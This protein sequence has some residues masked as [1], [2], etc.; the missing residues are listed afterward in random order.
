MLKVLVGAVRSNV[1]TGGVA[2]SDLNPAPSEA[3]LYVEQ[4]LM[5]SQKGQARRNIGTADSSIITL[6]GEAIARYVYQLKD[7]DDIVFYPQTIER[8]VIDDDGRTLHNK[9]GD[10]DD[11]ETRNKSSIVAAINEAAQTGSG[12]SVIL[13]YVVVNSIAEL[14]IPGEPTIGYLVGENLYVYVG[15]GGDT[16]SGAYQNC[17]AFRGPQGPQG[18]QGVQGVQ[19]VPGQDGEAAG[20]GTPTATVDANVGTPSVSVTASGPDTAK[21]FTFTFTNLKG[22]PGA[23]GADGAQGPPGVTSAVVT[24][25][26]TSG[27]PAAQVSVSEGVLTIAF[28]GLKGLQGNSG[29]SGAAGELQ[30][31]NNLVDGGTTDAL[32]AEMGK[33]LKGLIDGKFVFLTESE[34]AALT[35]KDPEKIYCTY[36]DEEEEVEE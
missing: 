17:G 34:Y 26:N 11:L 10:L 1:V 12:G 14:P 33:D 8:A 18:I 22:Q 16:R 25:D 7:S 2:L 4:E 21:V 28:T 20:F 3:V 30:V 32:S 24:V 9:L 5:E 29:Y 31:V 6:V 27:T 35:S 36:E 23:D 15:S 19:G 13:G